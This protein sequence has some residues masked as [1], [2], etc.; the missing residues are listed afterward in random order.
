MKPWITTKKSSRLLTSW[1]N[2]FLALD[3]TGMMFSGHEKGEAMVAG[4]GV[5]VID[6]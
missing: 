4:E 6:G 5:K 2:L 1:A 3:V